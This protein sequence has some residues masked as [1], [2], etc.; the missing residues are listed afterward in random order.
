MKPLGWAL[1]QCDWCPYKKRRWDR[2]KGRHR[3][4][5][6][7]TPGEGHAAVE[8]YRDAATLKDSRGH[9]SWERNRREIFPGAFGGSVF[10]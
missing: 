8:G 10:L 2:E 4:R 3:G 1:V 9:Q 5:T 6:V 7:E